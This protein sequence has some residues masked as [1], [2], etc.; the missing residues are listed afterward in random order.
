MQIKYIFKYLSN[1]SNYLFLN[2][3]ILHSHRLIAALPTLAACLMVTKHFESNHALR[4]TYEAEIAR[5]QRRIVHSLS[6]TWQ[7]FATRRRKA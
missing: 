4:W 1:T 2:D 6:M 5:I 3:F 7:H